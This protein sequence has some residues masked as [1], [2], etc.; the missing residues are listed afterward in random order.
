MKHRTWRGR[1]SYRGPDGAERGRE[2]FHVTRANDG[3]R[4]MRAVCEIDDSQVLRDVTLTVGAD[5][6]PLESYVRVC[7]EDRWIGSGWFRFADEAAYAEVES[8]TLGRLSQRM[9]T[10][11]DRAPMFGAH[12]VA[13]DGWQAGLLGRGETGPRRVEGVLLS[14]PL[15]NGASGPLLATTTLTIEQLG[16]ERIE[17]LAGTF[18]T[19]RYRC[20]PDDLPPEELWVLP[21]DN[22]LVRSVWTHYDTSYELAELSDK[23]A[24]G[25][26]RRPGGA[27]SDPTMEKRHA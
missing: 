25:G 15:P 11:G 19:V 18:D 16:P 23:P 5:W 8:A 12:Q 13:G 9:A 4:T 7:V 24:P 6:R 22:L 10:P 21:D 14:S 26:S 20:T 3:R 27:A 17:V 1:L 2:W